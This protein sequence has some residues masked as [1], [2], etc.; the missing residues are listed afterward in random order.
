MRCGL[1]W[2]VILIVLLGFYISTCRASELP[3]VVKH[4]SKVIQIPSNAPYTAIVSVWHAW[5][6]DSLKV[7]V[8]GQELKRVIQESE[9]TQGSFLITETDVVRFDA[10]QKGKKATLEFDDTPLRVAVFVTSDPSNSVHLAL[11]DTLRQ[12]GDEPLI[13][14]E[15]QAT[16]VKTRST[17]KRLVDFEHLTEVLHSD[18]LILV[19]CR[20]AEYPT[21]AKFVTARVRFDV[22]SLE[23]GDRIFMYEGNARVARA[24]DNWSAS[25]L[26]AVREAVK[27]A[28]E[29]W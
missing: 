3:G 25:R 4:R 15:V 12:L 10:A 5:N 29:E 9:L 16:V 18:R 6:H 17:G 14:A 23:T 28:T 24:V 8:D 13:G 1:L 26:K 7:R 22:Y 2:W 27:K 20:T 19:R 11:A 21:S